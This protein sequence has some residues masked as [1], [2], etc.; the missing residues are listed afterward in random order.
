MDWWAVDCNVQ[1]VHCPW[2]LSQWTSDLE[3]SGLL[4]ARCCPVNLS[5][6]ESYCFCHSNYFMATLI[7]SFTITSLLLFVSCIKN[8]S[9][10][11]S[12]QPPFRSDS[13]L[14]ISVFINFERRKNYH[15]KTFD[16]VWKTETE[17]TLEESILSTT[18]I[19]H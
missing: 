12:V 8:R 11:W 5:A 15:Y 19:D 18:R 13:L 10:L 7:L 6:K 16:S 4:K 3:I 17:G 9:F 14:R 2:G 1:G